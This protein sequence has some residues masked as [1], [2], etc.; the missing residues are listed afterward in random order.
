MS[1]ILY[2]Q[3][4][5]INSGQPVVV[6]VGGIAISAEDVGFDY[7]VGQIRHSVANGSPPLLRV[8]GAVLPR[9]SEM[10]PAARYS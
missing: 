6:V 1:L 3:R 9:R 2:L 10:D 7:Q 4:T 8:F 5:R